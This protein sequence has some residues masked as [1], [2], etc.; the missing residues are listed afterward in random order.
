M[1]ERLIPFIIL[2]II[3]EIYTYRAFKIAFGKK[4]TPKIIYLVTTISIIVVILYQAFNLKLNAGQTFGFQLM[5]GLF[6]L[7]Y[8]PKLFVFIPVLFQDIINGFIAG[9]NFIFRRKSVDRYFP[10]RKTFISKMALA[11]AALP[12]LGVL[13]GI[14]LGRFNFKIHLDR[15]FFD[16]LPQA[17]DGL[18]ILQI[19]DVHCGSILERDR[20]KIEEAV[21]LINEQNADLIV[22]TGDLVN[23]F[24]DEVDP[25]IDVLNKIKK[26]PFGNFAVMG[27]HDYGEYTRWKSEMAKKA[28]LE[29]IKSAFGKIGFDLL[30]NEHVSLTK[31]N[32]S[33][34]LI[35]VENWGSRFIQLGDLEKAIK[36]IQQEDFKIVLTHDPSH[37]EMEIKNDNFNYHLTFSGHTHGMQ[38]GI[39][40]PSMGI[41]W[42]PSQYIYKQWA[43]LYEHLGRYIYVNRGLGYHFFP[44]RISIWPEITVLELKKK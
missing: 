27:N 19:S 32:E 26:A 44:G 25:W 11:I 23:N 29:K 42:S 37:W 41:K 3:I 36:G 14:T 30:L 1:I 20:D 39:E 16:D 9:F 6:V 15:I 7:L 13:H 2:A 17:F 5:V 21:R 12:F 22:F 24:G 33:I 8:L 4:K 40:V 35:G 28:N 31:N 18:R 10:E 43:G 34:K 38:M